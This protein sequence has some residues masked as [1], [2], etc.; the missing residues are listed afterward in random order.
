MPLI[1]IITPVYNKE[2]YISN[3][4]ES[5]L[6]QSFENFEY[7]IVNDGST[8]G[9][10]AIVNEYAQK[11]DR[12]NV[13]HQQNQWIYASFN[14][15][16]KKASGEYI[17][18]LNADD[19]LRKNALKIM[20]DKIYKFHPDVIW[21]KVLSHKSDNEQNILEYDYAHLDEMVKEDRYQRDK[22]EFKNEWLFLN[23]SLLTLN[24]ANLYKRD[25]M[26]KHPFRNDVYAADTLFN[27]TIADEISSSYIL[28]EPVYDFFEYADF[29]NASAGKYHDYEHKMFNDIYLEHKNLLRKWGSDKKIAEYISRKRLRN[30]STELYNYRYCTT[31]TAE[32]KL[33]K[34]LTDMEDNIVYECAQ[35]IDAL[36]ELERRLL[37][38]VKYIIDNEGIDKNSEF[39]Y[40][41]D[42]LNI[43]EK[44]QCIIDDTKRIINRIDN[45]YNI[46][47]CFEQV[48]CKGEIGKYIKFFY[49]K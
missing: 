32:E 20:A 26:L 31:L 35:N 5:V 18:I 8:D 33:K 12:I 44:Q 7:I 25:L 42:L 38:G 49:G 48:L 11:D 28:S 41:N 34:I 29:G 24:Q 21:T 10:A 46:G 13:I 30:Y 27:I 23:T 17:Y 2:K 4:V 6:N 1:S 19:K 16:I 47:S 22:E 36:P 39:A 3:A 9:S 45:K 43:F 14:N 15:G 40:L 37:F